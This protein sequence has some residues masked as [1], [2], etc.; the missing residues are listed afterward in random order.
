MSMEIGRRPREVSL[1]SRHHLPSRLAWQGRLIWWGWLCC[2]IALAF[3]QASS[4]PAY[5][6]VGVFLLLSALYPECA[7]K[8][9]R[10]S[11]VPWVVVA[12]GALSVVWSEMPMASARA[13][14]QI[15]ITTV[16]AIMFAQSLPA[17]S[18]IA[19]SM[20]AVLASAVA[21][22]N[23]FQVFGS[24]NSLALAFTV[25]LLSSL[26]VMIDP[27]QSVINRSVALASLLAGPPMLLEANSE[28]ALLAG[29]VALVCSLAPLL[30]R[31]LQ[32]RT[33]VATIVIGM[34]VAILVAATAYVFLDG[35]YDA[36]LASIGKDTSLTGRTLLWSRAADVI[37]AHPWGGVGLQAFWYEGNQDA[38][39]F[40]SYFY[41]YSHRGFHFHNLWL[42]T[43]VEL[44]LFGILFVALTTLR[45]AYSIIRWALRDPSPESCFF[46]GFLVFV[47]VRTFGEVELYVQFFLVPVVFIAGYVYSASSKAEPERPGGA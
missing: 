24:K 31:S 15:A 45:I 30:L 29:G 37:A 13:A 40:W 43:G 4:T 46:L 32:T 35:L 18:F 34:F 5:V 28:G 36:M 41:I 16:V 26:W 11:L 14:V 17:R 1:G 21:Y 22:A 2:S 10:W 19:T 27:R 38:E 44:G 3:S 33:R 7:Y 42:E 8:A 39:R 12:F 20:Y 23:H 9:L 6:L 47:L 25:L